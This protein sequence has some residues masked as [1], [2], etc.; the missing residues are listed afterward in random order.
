DPTAMLFTTAR[1]LEWLGRKDSAVATA[2]REL[3][4]AVAA[5]LAE[6]AGKSRGTQEIGTAVRERLE[7]LTRP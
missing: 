6:N 4:D 7:T 3:F 2:G 1:M 5:D